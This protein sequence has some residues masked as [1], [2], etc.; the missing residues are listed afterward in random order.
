MRGRFDQLHD[1]PW[2][3]CRGS[4]R[5]GPSFRKRWDGAKA[6]RLR[7]G[8]RAEPRPPLRGFPGVTG[9]RPGLRSPPPRPPPPSG[10][11]L[12]SA[13]TGSPRP[14]LGAPLTVRPSPASG[15]ASASLAHLGSAPSV[16][17]WEP[18]GGGAGAAGGGGGRCGVSR[19]SFGA[20]AW[21]CLSSSGFVSQM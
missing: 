10:V 3:P 6:L 5:G 12:G 9:S 18:G 17:C 11:C 7:G 21:L 13:G 20:A 8:S 4:A 2:S 19:C 14:Q 1:G 16:P 15:P